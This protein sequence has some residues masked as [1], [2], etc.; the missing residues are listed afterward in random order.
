MKILN[1]VL[2]ALVGASA[3]LIVV[4]CSQQDERLA[5]DWVKVSSHGTISAVWRF[6]IGDDGNARLQTN[7][8]TAHA[9]WETEDNKYLLFSE[10]NGLLSRRC[11]YEFTK[12]DAWDADVLV[13]DGCITTHRHP[14]EFM[15]TEDV[16]EQRRN[17]AFQ[18]VNDLYTKRSK[19]DHSAVYELTASYLRK[20][21]GRPVTLEEFIEFSRNEASRCDY[22][23]WEWNIEAVNVSNVL[24]EQVV[25][26]TINVQDDLVCSGVEAVEGVGVT[27]VLIETKDGWQLNDVF[28]YKR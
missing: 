19:G 11:S 8:F 4:G 14:Q 13:L 12:F 15:K 20:L 21:A 24:S 9:K 26:A 25:E 22:E 18:F 27:I 17:D 3:L 6:D 7:D 16:V 23:N 5:G 10:N 2:L 28:D 1:F